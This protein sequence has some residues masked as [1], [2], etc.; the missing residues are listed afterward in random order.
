MKTQK[1]QDS[2]GLGGWLEQPERLTD[3]CP[4]P[5][6]QLLDILTRLR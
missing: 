4:S 6:L 1:P 3:P 2:L 5:G